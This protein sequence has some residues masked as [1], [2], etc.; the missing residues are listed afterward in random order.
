MTSKQ[1]QTK[2]L[3]EKL[4]IAIVGHRARIKEERKAIQTAKRN[5]KRHKLLMKQANTTTKIQLLDIKS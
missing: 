5:I 1:T 3:L 2:E 4:S